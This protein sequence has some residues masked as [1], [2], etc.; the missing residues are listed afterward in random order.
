MELHNSPKTVA[1]QKFANLNLGWCDFKTHAV[2]I[3]F[4][5]LPVTGIISQLYT[6]GSQR[7]GKGLDEIETVSEMLEHARIPQCWGDRNHLKTGED[8]H[9]PKVEAQLITTQ[10][11][12]ESI[13]SFI[14]STAMNVSTLSVQGQ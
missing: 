10:L 1:N 7:E 3:Y 8:R 13:N 11:A 6:T 2:F 12:L 4:P 9:F 5:R 14:S